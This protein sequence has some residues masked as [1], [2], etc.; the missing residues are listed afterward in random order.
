MTLTSK[1]CDD[2]MSVHLGHAQNWQ[3]LQTRLS[4]YYWTK[5]ALCLLCPTKGQTWW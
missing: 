4:F 1:D 5:M 3:M 2:F